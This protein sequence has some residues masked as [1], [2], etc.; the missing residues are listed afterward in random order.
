MANIVEKGIYTVKYPI[1]HALTGAVLVS[2]GQFDFENIRNEIS[3]KAKESYP[4]SYTSAQI[5]NANIRISSF[6]SKLET[7]TEEIILSGGT[8]IDIPS[9]TDIERLRE[10]YE[11][12]KLEG[13]RAKAESDY[14]SELHANRP[15]ERIAR[16]FL[17]MIP[18]ILLV[19]SAFW[20]GLSIQPPTRRRT[21]LKAT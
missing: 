21:N 8:I 2:V 7:H 20:R 19:A 13:L 12:R 17:L 5:D 3:K 1:T 18:G 16:P 6:K 15:I 14:K 4:S 9:L 10:S 11:I